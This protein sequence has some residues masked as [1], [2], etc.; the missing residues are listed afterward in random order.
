MTAARLSTL[1]IGITFHVLGIPA[2][3]Q[4]RAQTETIF[5]ATDAANAI[6][7]FERHAKQ[8]VVVAPQS[9]RIDARGELSG[10]V[11]QQILDIARR[12]RVRVMPLVVNPGWNLEIFSTMVNDSSART[13]MI[14]QMVDLGTRHGYW[15]WQ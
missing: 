7:S 10:S 4:Q 12:N 6:E 11:P 13:R 3:A 8:V 1:L 15:G 2:G 14:A 5:Y 9:Y